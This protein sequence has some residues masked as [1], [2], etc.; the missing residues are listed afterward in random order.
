M[1]KL[2]A[3]PHLPFVSERDIDLLLVEELLVSEKFARFFLSKLSFDSHFSRTLGAW[4]SVTVAGLGESD[5]VFL[6]VADGGATIAVLIENK[7]DAQ[8]M[9]DQS[10]RYLRRGEVGRKKNEW[11]DFHTCMIAPLSYLDSP[12]RLGGYQSVIS[13]EEV[14]GFFAEDKNDSRHAFRLKML[15]AGIQQFRRGYER[16]TH[17][18]L[19]QFVREYIAFAELN[20][21]DLG[22][23]DWVERPPTNDWIDF[24][25]TG[26]I[27]GLRVVHQNAGGFVKVFFGQPSLSVSTYTSAYTTADGFQVTQTKAGT[28]SVARSVPKN[29]GKTQSF[30]CRASEVRLALESL[31]ILLDA[32]RKNQHI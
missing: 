24:Y 2:T 16:V 13:Y 25:P 14:A 21:P 3:Q 12:T 20:F 8:E 27:Q 18:T 6:F 22:V 30:V 15:E 26:K 31:R 1:T 23:Q 32:M 5:I 9:T 17:P 11:D 10:R 7:I 4:Q 28:I 29:D 19:S